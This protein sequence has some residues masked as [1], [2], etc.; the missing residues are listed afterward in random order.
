[1]GRIGAEA[2]PRLRHQPV[3]FVRAFHDRR[4]VRVITGGKSALLGDVG[5]LVE[6]SR[7][8]CVVRVRGAVG[9]PRPS[10][11]DQVAS[12]KLLGQCRSVGDPVEFIV[13][14]VGVNEVAAGV[15]RDQLKACVGQEA[16]EHVGLI[17][18][19]RDVPVEHLDPRIAR[20][21]DVGDRRRH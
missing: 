7:E 6:C 3:Q 20:P 2:D 12:A 21:G 17:G 19:V 18:I 8:G 1:V 15:H 5:H 11:D 16:P 4:Q 13:E 10:S 14:Q 9:A